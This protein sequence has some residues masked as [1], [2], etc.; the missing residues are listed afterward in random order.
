MDI[1]TLAA[2]HHRLVVDY[3]WILDDN[4]DFETVK[5]H[6]G[7]SCVIEAYPYDQHCISLKTEGDVL[8]LFDEEDKQLLNI[9]KYVAFH[10][11]EKIEI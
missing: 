2:P 10:N 11:D 4:L 7:I 1:G 9:H 6:D 8:F 5:E 3:G